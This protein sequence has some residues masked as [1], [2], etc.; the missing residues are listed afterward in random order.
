MTGKPLWRHRGL[1]A[2]L[3]VLTACQVPAVAPVSPTGST[4]PFAARAITG[5]LQTHF[6]YNA[7]IFHTSQAGVLRWYSDSSNG[8][9]TAG[10]GNT[11]TFTVHGTGIH[12]YGSRQARG[13]PSIRVTIDG[14]PYTFSCYN[15]GTTT[16]AF[17]QELLAVSG[18]TNGPHTVTI[19]NPTRGKYTYLYRVGVDVPGPPIVR[20]HLFRPM[21]DSAGAP[22]RPDMDFVASRYAAYLFDRS[23]PSTWASTIQPAAAYLKSR[24][25][26]IALYAT[27]SLT[28]STPSD[29]NFAAADSG[30]YG[31]TTTLTA[32]ITAATTAIPVADGSAFPLLNF[33]VQ[34][35]GER[36]LCS[37]RI[38][39]TLNV[40]LAPYNGRAIRTVAVPP[41]AAPHALGATVS[42]PR[43]DWFLHDNTTGARLVNPTGTDPG[44]IMD[45]RNAGWVGQ[46]ASTA[47]ATAGS[48]ANIAGLLLTK[49]GVISGAG[50]L[51]RV[52]G[53]AGVLPTGYAV[54]FSTSITPALGTIQAALGKPLGISFSPNNGPVGSQNYTNVQATWQEGVG[55]LVIS[56]DATTI[57]AASWN[58]QQSQWVGQQSAGIVTFAQGG[59]PGT[60]SATANRNMLYALGSYLLRYN[61]LDTFGFWS[62]GYGQYHPYYD[63]TEV[64]L[65][66]P[67][68]ASYA[69]GT[70]QRR[71][72]QNGV[73]LVNPNAGTVVYPFG[74]TLH[75]LSNGAITSAS[76]NIPRVAA[77]YTAQTSASIPAASAVIAVFATP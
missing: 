61:G 29:F 25:P 20:R 35:D 4:T 67:L 34:I 46:V 8:L 41:V 59:T 65:G 54:A 70:L 31:P 40:Q 75:V 63:A 19:T 77:V 12:L 60:G 71:N 37:S 74:N 2:A 6:L 50:A 14:T 27:D 51:T 55:H 10:D 52:H 9:Y 32:A 21:P 30:T 39:N 11:V 64:P 22:D 24:N 56:P 5:G 1:L 28:T 44:Y 38:G 53:G 15:G 18:L 66:S 36:I 23:L 49:V 33:Y 13:A 73:V 42:L 48:D 3:L 68:G 72:F 26:A 17:D 47:A 7:G 76:P 69:D 16:P 45:I 62:G 58:A 57:A 43:E